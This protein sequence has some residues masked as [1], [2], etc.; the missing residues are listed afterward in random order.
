MVESEEEI[1]VGSEEEAEDASQGDIVVDSG[2]DVIGSGEESE[3][4]SEDAPDVGAEATE[5]EDISL[6]LE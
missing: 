4:E 1:T 3:F 5:T 6:I 2:E